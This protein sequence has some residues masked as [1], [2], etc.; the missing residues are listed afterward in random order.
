MGFLP[1]KP[2]PRD[3]ALK[4]VRAEFKKKASVREVP[5]A[6]SVSDIMSSVVRDQGLTGSCTSQA[7]GAG[8]MES[9]SI[10]HASKWPSLSTL[11]LYYVT[12]A[13]NRQTM[14][15]SG[16]SLRDTMKAAVKIGTCSEELWPYVGSK[17]ASRPTT[18]AYKSATFRIKRYYSVEDLDELKF[19]I[20]CKNPVV[21]GI[22]LWSSFESSSTTKTGIVSLPNIKKEKLLGGHAICATAY[23]NAG[24][25]DGKGHVVIRNSW[26]PNWGEKGYCFL[27]YE[28]FNPDRKLATDYWTATA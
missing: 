9:L 8:L 16:A 26:G 6:A 1:D 18:A 19:A 22:Y 21:L 13:R 25:M 17:F 2:D 12:R 10:E 27:P 3:F 4:S 28:Y 15:D 20:A 5:S 14:K 23:D 24:G 7:V 11:F